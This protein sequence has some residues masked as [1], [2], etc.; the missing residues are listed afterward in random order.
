VRTPSFNVKTTKPLRFVEHV[1][2]VNVLPGKTL[3]VAVAGPQK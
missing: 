3:S 1:P 2:C